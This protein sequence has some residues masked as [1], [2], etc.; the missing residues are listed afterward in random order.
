MKTRTLDNATRATDPGRVVVSSRQLFTLQPELRSHA[1]WLWSLFQHQGRYGFSRAFLLTHIA[2]H[3]WYGDSRAAV[4]VKTSPLLVAA[5]TDEMDC[6][7]L[8][9]FEDAWLG[10]LRPSVGDRLL[11]VNTYAR[12]RFGYAADILPGNGLGGRYGNMSPF[13][14]EAFSEDF[15][16]IEQRKAQIS[17]DEWARSPVTVGEADIDI[18]LL[19]DSLRLTPWERLMEN[20]WALAFVRMLENARRRGNGTSQSN[21]RTTDS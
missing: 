16:T 1:A 15:G 20:D 5:Y 7:V 14:A 12:L 9:R 8:L 11:T 17:D 6:V 19:E 21:P 18:S 13:I 2:E 4:V 10:D 3:L